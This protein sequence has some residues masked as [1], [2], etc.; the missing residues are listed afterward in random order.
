MKTPTE[1]K[2]H[3]QSADVTPAQAGFTVTLDGR[4]P[5]TPAGGRLV[6]PY[7]AL[8]RVIAA[9]WGAQG[10]RVVIASM[11]TTRL[12]HVAID[13]ATAAHD[14]LAARIAEFA[15][16]D[17]LCYF[18]DAPAALVARQ[19]AT[20]TPI[21]TWAEAA[22]G[23]SFRRRTGVVHVDQ[24]PETL[25]AVRRLAADLDD[26]ALT[27]LVA[28]AQLFGSAILAIALL[29]GRLNGAEAFLASQLDEIFQAEAWGEDVEAAERRAAMAGEA[30]ALE[31]WFRALSAPDAASSTA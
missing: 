11:P 7:E 18:A 31:V 29:R 27:G 1:P 6:L 20:W 15:A 13:A 4:V 30:E 25:E 2:R 3:Y 17:L 14:E 23:L 24:P 26:F 21:M 5:R 19:A 8:A 28:A 16:H 12:A 22:L 10:E 9:E